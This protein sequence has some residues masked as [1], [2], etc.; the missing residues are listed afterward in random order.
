MRHKYPT[1]AI[2]LART[3]VA[4]ESALLTLLTRDVGLVRARAQGLRKSGAKLAGVLPTL[5]ES[6]IVLVAG[7][8]GWR[9]AG[10]LSAEN[11]FLRLPRSAREAAGRV[12]ALLM[13]LVGGESPDPALYDIYAAFLAA[14]ASLPEAAY[15]AA[16]CLAALRILAALG[17]DAGELPE[18]S[19]EF[20]IE[21]LRDVERQR[22]K[23]VARVNHGIRASGL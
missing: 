1:R 6:D 23:L 2:V 11:W 21:A 17:L 9:V 8:D 13:R 3:S 4:E 15:G 18:G 19:G 14:L 10:A 7:K 16:E 22:S 20:S 5:A 12:A